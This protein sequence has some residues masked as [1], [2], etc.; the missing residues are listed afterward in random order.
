MQHKLYTHIIQ[1]KYTA[2]EHVGDTCCKIVIGV[3][4]SSHLPQDTHS[5]IQL[6]RK[7][8]YQT[9]PSYE[10]RVHRDHRICRN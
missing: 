10:Q 3:V 5:H 9:T 6:G 8:I 1:T 7:D 2:I 4:M